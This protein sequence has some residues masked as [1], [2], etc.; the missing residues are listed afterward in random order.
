[1]WVTPCSK[2]PFYEICQYEQHRF[3]EKK[4]VPCKKISLNLYNFERTQK[5]WG[6]FQCSFDMGLG[7]AMK[8]TADSSF[9]SKEIF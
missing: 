6:Q 3:R 8:D 7:V 2:L 4:L 9:F 5:L 1:M